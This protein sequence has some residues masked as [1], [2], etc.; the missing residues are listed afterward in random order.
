MRPYERGL[1]NAPYG[2][3]FLQACQIHTSHKHLYT[4]LIEQRGA[5]KMSF[6]KLNSSDWFSPLLTEV[7]EITGKLSEAL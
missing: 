3:V 5:K 6:L 4:S 1:V 7:D 2:A